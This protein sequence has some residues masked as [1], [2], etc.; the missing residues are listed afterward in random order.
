MRLTRHHGLPGCPHPFRVLV[1]ATF[2]LSVLASCQGGAENDPT[3]TPPV[4]SETPVPTEQGV[5]LRPVVWTTGVDRG[6]GEPTD[7][8]EVFPRDTETIYA[9][10]EVMNMPAGSRLTAAWEIN[11]RPVAGLESTVVV[12]KAQPLGWAEFH[13]TW[14]GQTMW[15]VGTLRIVITASTGES[16]ESSVRIE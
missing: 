2:A 12:D 16:I 15:P 5:R 11:D 8:V 6:T 9:A 13:L 1:A 7:R 14:K 3:A 10:L 4:V